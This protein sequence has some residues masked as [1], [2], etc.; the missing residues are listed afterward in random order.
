[1]TGGDHVRLLEPF[2]DALAGEAGMVIGHQ[3]DLVLVSWDRRP[4][5]VDPVPARI[6]APLG[7]RRAVLRVSKQGG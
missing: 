2:G 6:L 7:D 5:N 3:G 1:V 4:L